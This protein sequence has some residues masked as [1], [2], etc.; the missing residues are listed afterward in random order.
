MS[1][2]FTLVELLVVIGILVVLIA[3]LLPVLSKARA[4]A[5]A[6]NCAARHRQLL[7]GLHMYAEEHGGRYSPVYPLFA[8]VTVN[9]ITR[10]GARVA[11]YGQPLVGRYIGNRHASSTA[12]PP[13]QQWS[14]TDLVYCPA[15]QGL[16][17]SNFDTGIGYNNSR[18]NEI[19]RTDPSNPAVGPVRKLGTFRYS[20]KVILTVDTGSIGGSTFS[21]ERYYYHQSGS[22]TGNDNL[23]TGY[24]AYRHNKAVTVGFA[25]GHVERILSNH[26]DN[27][28]DMTSGLYKAYL[29]KLVT[30]RAGH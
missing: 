6:V 13:A 26:P 20:S 19:N 17:R 9:N 2:G 27:P 23:G 22:V 25:D 15:V 24:P 16:S 8:S 5:Q 10:T 1:K 11:W 30:H 12:F 7:L 21:W 14:S 3:M 28:S 18:Q 29:D 4:A